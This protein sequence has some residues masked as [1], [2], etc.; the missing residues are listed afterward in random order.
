[1]RG[2][3]DRRPG[4][5]QRLVTSLDTRARSAPGA[6]TPRQRRR[7]PGGA[8][9]VLAFWPQYLAISP[10]Y[11]LFAVFGLFPV[12]FT[13]YLA[14]QRWDGI[15]D[16][17]SAGFDNFTYMFADDTFW[18]AVWNTIVMWLLSTVPTLSLALVLAVLMNSVKRFKGLY[19]MAFFIPNIT[20]TVAIS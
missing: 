9:R 4:R 18:L 16:M 6:E 5:S 7:A 3:E 1:V 8:R 2:E 14:F 10:F 12:L 20:S 19:R 11:V 15:G 17:R 13:F